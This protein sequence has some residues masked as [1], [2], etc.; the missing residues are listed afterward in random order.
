M[1][2]CAFCAYGIFTFMHALSYC[3][4]FTV[5]ASVIAGY[6]LGGP[7]AFLTAFGICLL[8]PFLDWMIG[9]AP[10]RSAERESEDRAESISFRVIMWLYVP[11]QLALV[12]F[13][14]VVVSRGSLSVFETIG[15]IVSIAITTG[16]VG[17]TISHELCHQ[18]N[19]LENFMGRLLLMTV[20]YMHFCLEHNSGHHFH[21][22]TP[23]DPASARLGESFY[24]F[25][26]R[27]LAGSFKSAWRLER[28][29][30]KEKGY[31]LWSLQNQM[32][33]FILLPLWVASAFGILLGISAFVNFLIQ[34]LI[35]V[36]LLEGVNYVQH[37]G[38][39]RKQLSPGRYERVTLAHAWNSNH[40]LTNL[41]LFRL[42]L[43][44]DHH[45]S[46][47]RRYQI[48]RNFEQCPRLPLG[49]AGMLPL[50][51]V[52]PLWR[53]VMDPRALLYRA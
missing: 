41:F 8:L 45:V 30:L 29:R 1:R 38:L 12:I 9:P 2:F 4:A 34:S 16:V 19:R 31:A 43:H 49:F 17:V 26:L 44:S 11:I 25:F 32:L 53:K 48:L 33:W 15:L 20:S 18:T 5:P 27:S 39:Q 50:V 28:R 52:P 40:K 42:Q 7:F 6:L 37:Y 24:A 47:L 21:V 23:E 36:T 10:D 22:C 46:P 3:L 35:A 51:L 14:A 13:G